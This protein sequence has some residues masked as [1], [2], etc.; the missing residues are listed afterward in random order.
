MVR[1]IILLHRI[2]EIA[3][4]AMLIHPICINAA[5]KNI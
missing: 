1:L 5:N 3:L 2:S 4:Y